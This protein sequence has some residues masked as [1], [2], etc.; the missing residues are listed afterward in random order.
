MFSVSHVNDLND[1][2][3]D[4]FIVNTDS[5]YDIIEVNN[6]VS[7]FIFVGNDLNKIMINNNACNNY[8]IKRPLDYNKLDEIL[9]HIR[10]KIQKNFIIASTPDGERKICIKH[11]NYINI[12]NRSLCYHLAN[13]NDCYSL[14]LTG[15]FKKAISPLDKHDLLLFISPSLLINISK[16]KMIDTNII[17]FDDNTTFYASVPQRKIIYE[18]WTKFYDFE[19]RY[20]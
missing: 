5:H 13:Q 2:D 12:I 3:V 15:S 7:Y 14:S 16:I 9:F 17:T 6:T 4:I 20:R 18:E 1:S 19:N 8:F 10:K 11:L